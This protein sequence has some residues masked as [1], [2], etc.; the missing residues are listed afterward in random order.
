MGADDLPRHRYIS[1]HPLLIVCMNFNHPVASADQVID[2]ANLYRD[3]FYKFHRFWRDRSDLALGLLFAATFAVPCIG[4]T[5]FQGDRANFRPYY[6]AFGFTAIAICGLGLTDALRFSREGEIGSNVLAEIRINASEDLIEQ[7][8][9]RKF[10]PF[11]SPSGTTE[12]VVIEAEKTP[13]EPA[14]ENIG[15]TVSKSSL[16]VLLVGSTGSGKTTALEAILLGIHRSFPEADATFFD[17]K[18]TG[19]RG[20]LGIKNTSNYISVAEPSGIPQFYEAIDR[21]GNM[22][23]S[24]K[25]GGDSRKSFVIVD[26][27]NNAIRKARKYQLDQKTLPADAQDKMDYTKALQIANDIVISQGREKNCIGIATTHEAT[28]E[29][30]GQGSGMRSNNRFVILGSKDSFDNIES[31]LSGT[32]AKLITNPDTIARLK[33]QYQHHKA[34]LFSGYFALT[35]V[36]GDWRLVRLPDWSNGFPL[37]FGN[38][39]IGD[40][41]FGEEMH[42]FPDDWENGNTDDEDDSTGYSYKNFHPA[43]VSRV[44]VDPPNRGESGTSSSMEISEEMI[45]QVWAALAQGMTKTKIIQDILGMKGR[46][47]AAGVELYGRIIQQVEGAS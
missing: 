5:V 40:R 12:T 3:S 22:L 14:I 25:R 34:L 19:D 36:G 15:D 2:R 7:Q 45:E 46:R 26:E 41:S 11:G 37:V 33:E 28:T 24:A 29:A 27:L 18:P 32:G 44:L 6:E 38:E 23:M 4:K 8:A 13:H 9:E 1:T 35:N 20:L 30:L 47:Y 43:I 16:P 10:H 42:D 31:I 21:Y 17:G 39:E